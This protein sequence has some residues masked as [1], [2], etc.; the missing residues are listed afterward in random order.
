[1][2]RRRG[3]RR[4]RSPELVDGAGGARRR[5]RWRCA[6]G[7]GGSP[8]GSWWGGRA[9]WAVT[10]GRRAR[11]RSRWWGCAWTGVRRWWRRCWR[12]GW[13]GRRT[14]RWIRP[15]RPARLAF[16]LADAGAAMVAGTGA[17]LESLPAGRVP[18]VE[19]DDPRTAAAVAG[20]APVAPRRPAAGALAYVMLHVGV[21]GGAEGRGGDARGAGELP[22]VGAVAAGLGRAGR[23]V[24]AAAVPGDGPGEHAWCWPRWPPAGCCTCR[25]RALAADPACGG[26]VAGRAAEWSI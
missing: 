20:A 18:V 22:G 5:M 16:M 6:A 14:C 11:V 15:T 21:D 19:L 8:T 10:C 17:A 1:M 24:R 3:F 13:R 2:T 12:C 26:G 4:G 23:P 9:G 25:G 7:T